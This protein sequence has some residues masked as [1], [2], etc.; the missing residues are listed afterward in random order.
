MLGAN[1]GA[2]GEIKA[3]PSSGMTRERDEGLSRIRALLACAAGA[4]FLIACANVISLLLGHAFARSYETSLR[5]ALGARRGQLAREMLSDSVFISLA[6]GAFGTLLAIWT[7]RIVPALLFEGD[8]EH[9]V[10]APRLFTIVAACTAC[11]GVMIV[12]GLVPVFAT[13]DD[14]PQAVLRREYAGPSKRM[15]YLRAG[16]V[17]AQMTSCCILV[18]SAA[19]LLDGLHAAL[20]TS[21]GQRVGDPI[22]ATEQAQPIT[23]I[24]YFEDVQQA[25]RS[26][27]GVSSMAWA[28]RLPGDQPTWQSFRIEPEHLP[29]RGITMDVV[30]FTAASLKFFTLPPKSGRLF[31]FEGQTCRVAIVNESAAATLF[32]RNTVGRTIQDSAGLSVEIIGTVESKVRQGPEG[33]RPTIYY[34]ATNQTGPAPTGIRFARFRAPINSNLPTAELDVNVVSPSYFE[35]MGLSLI[36]GQEF[37]GHPVPGACRIAVVNQEAAQLYFGG[38]AVGAAVINNEGVRTAIV[39]VVH[40]NPLEVFQ[41]HTEPAIY[42]PM[43]QDCLRYMTLIVGVRRV[44]DVMLADVRRK[45]EAVP[46]RGPAPIVVQTLATHLAHTAL[47]PLRIATVI[48]GAS[49]ATALTLA[50]VGLVGVLS[51]AARQ[52]RRDLAIRIALGAQRWRVIGLVLREGGRLFCA[53]T[54]AGML[55]SLALSRFL[56]AITP[57]RVPALWVWLAA[58]LALAVVVLIASILPVRRA[59]MVNPVALMRDDR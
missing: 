31:G 9:L 26:M 45:I 10:F 41:Q 37:T 43:R 48:I 52:R 6:G 11:A 44:N 53:G 23:G 49:A 13:S 56:N 25:V 57:G 47:A 14:H 34:N 12:C 27:A 36:A 42:F 16:L 17:V 28:G 58:P 7:I 32:G 29:L 54:L 39:G 59:L 5:V 4:V 3:L 20:Q 21:A 50:F 35:T 33:N 22:L 2:S 1:R 18:V 51:D 40:S 24:R 46:G 30:W 38:K 19:F 15:R 8:A 55:G